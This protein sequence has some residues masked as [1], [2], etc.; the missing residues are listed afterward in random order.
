MDRTGEAF[1]LLV[2]ENTHLREVIDALRAE[3]ERLSA[4]DGRATIELCYDD[5]NNP[6]AR[7]ELQVADV[8]VADNVY[9]V[10]SALVNE[11]RAENERLKDAL[12]HC[13]QDCHHAN[14]EIER[15]LA[16]LE[17]IAEYWNGDCNHRAMSDALDHILDS[18]KQALGAAESGEE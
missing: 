6:F 11:L 7:S 16:A 18:A 2:D 10:E 8:G 5:G 15:L 14:E 9:V 13:E 1:A 17:H 4:R 3:N 12:I